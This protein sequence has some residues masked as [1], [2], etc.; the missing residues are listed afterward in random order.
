MSIV[1]AVSPTAIALTPEGGAIVPLTSSAPASTMVALPPTINGPATTRPAPSSSEKPEASK[2]PSVAIRLPVPIRLAV[3]NAAPLVALP[4]SVPAMRVP[5]SPMV[6]A[7]ATRLVVPAPPSLSNPG[8]PIVAAVTPRAI[9]EVPGG[10]AIVPRTSSAPVSTIVVLLPVVSGPVRI[11]SVVLSSAKRDAVKPASVPIALAPIR[12]TGC[13]APPSAALPLSVPAIRSP[14]SPI[15]PALAIRFVLPA[16]PSLTRPGMSIAAAVSPTAIAA[17][18]AG[19]AIVPLTSNA[20]VSTIVALPDAVSG[21]VTVRSVALSSVKS[22]AVKPPNAR[23]ELAPIRLTA[24]GALPLVALPLSVPAIRVPV[25]LIVPA[26]AIRLVVPAPPSLTRPGMAMLAAVRLTALVAIR[27][28]DTVNVSPVLIVMLLAVSVLPMV[29]GVAFDSAKLPVALNAPMVPMALEPD[30]RM[31]S[32]ATP[33]PLVSVPAFSMPPLV[34]VM[35]PEVV[36]LRSIVAAVSLAAPRLI[37][38]SAC[39]VIEPVAA[40]VVRSP[41]STSLPPDPVLVPACMT[42]LPMPDAVIDD[43]ILM[44][45]VWVWSV[46]LLSTPR[47][48]GAPAFSVMV[49]TACSRMFASSESSSKSVTVSVPPG[50]SP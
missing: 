17:V 25:S 33:L 13:G 50:W 16:P 41:F 11:R 26:L 15:V 48:S 10:G 9:A 43:P 37:P 35:P 8:M 6:P 24:W 40:S 27:L 20:P 14:V 31:A 5:V 30:I 34:W 23:I 18:P 49:L 22:A 12:L 21:P 45:P 38:P 28:F 46:K 2:L 3:C 36:V 44:S 4:V 1:A 39:K 32:P 19:G 47:V 7:F 42:M 29:S